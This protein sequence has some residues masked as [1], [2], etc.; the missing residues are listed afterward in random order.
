[1]DKVLVKVRKVEIYNLFICIVSLYLLKLS[2]KSLCIEII[3]YNLLIIKK[4]N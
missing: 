2:F 3:E 4:V 1:M